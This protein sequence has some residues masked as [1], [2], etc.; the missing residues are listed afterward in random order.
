READF[1]YA[2][3]IDMC[4]L[5]LAGRSIA[6]SRAPLVYEVLDVQRIFLGE[7]IVS[8][9]FR[10]AERRLLRQCDLLVISSPGFDRHYFRSVQG[11]RG[12]LFLLENKISFAQASAV[13][14][15]RPE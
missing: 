1:F 11:Y 8:R 3:N 12:R 9:L 13:P 2:R 15:P 5:A 4:A 7:R 14:R 10:W 6:G